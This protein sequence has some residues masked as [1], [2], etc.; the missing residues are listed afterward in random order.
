SATIQDFHAKQGVVYLKSDGAVD[1]ARTAI[2]DREWLAKEATPW[3]ELEKKGPHVF[4]GEFGAFDKSPHAAVLA[5]MEDELATWKKAGWGWALWNFR[6]E[7][8]ILDSERADVAYEP[9]H[10]HELDRKML[11]LLQRYQP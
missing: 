10:G 4:V 9:F 3:K 6:G 8:G 2:F 1:T 7:F 11:T 5:W